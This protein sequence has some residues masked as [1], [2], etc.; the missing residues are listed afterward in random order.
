[1]PRQRFFLEYCSVGGG[2]RVY[3]GQSLLSLDQLQRK[4]SILIPLFNWMMA[5][6]IEIVT[7]QFLQKLANRPSS[8]S[9]TIREVIYFMV[10]MMSI[11]VNMERGKAPSQGC[12][13]HSH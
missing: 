10:T 4:D 2:V 1:M 8:E 12:D 11:I 5:R 7:F 9:S 6:H 13:K 3:N